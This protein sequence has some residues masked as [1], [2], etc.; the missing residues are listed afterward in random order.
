MVRT[1]RQHQT[2]NHSY[3]AAGSDVSIGQILLFA[4][5]VGIV[6]WQT[7]PFF[8][9]ATLSP[10]ERSK[11]EASVHYAGCDQV[12][13]AGKAPLYSGQPGY[14]DGMDGDGD[15]VACE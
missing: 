1:Q 3:D 9:R 7:I 6:T 14:R 8:E 13:S 4:I 2:H 11:I 15:G 10:E 5:F 12:R